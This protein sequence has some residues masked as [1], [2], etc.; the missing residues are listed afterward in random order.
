MRGAFSVGW[1]G[2]VGR[3]VVVSRGRLGRSGWLGLGCGRALR[4]VL[5]VCFAYDL[6]TERLG[7]GRER[8]D[9]RHA[10]A[11]PLP[12]L[13]ALAASEPKR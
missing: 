6:S 7:T 4:E 8:R 10:R 11:Q 12:G 2:R 1:R 13:A 9:E 5:A 3:S